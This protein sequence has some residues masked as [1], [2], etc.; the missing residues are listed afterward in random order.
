VI[1]CLAIEILE[2]I[3]EERGVQTDVENEKRICLVVD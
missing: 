3:G 2:E 1:V